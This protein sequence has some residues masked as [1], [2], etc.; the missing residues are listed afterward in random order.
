MT[1]QPLTPELI[2]SLRRQLGLTQSEFAQRLGVSMQA[3]S[4]WERG[5]RTPTG[6]YARAIRSLLRDEPAKV[7]SD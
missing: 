2:R 1:D 7:A 4:F 3:V 6:L 5:T